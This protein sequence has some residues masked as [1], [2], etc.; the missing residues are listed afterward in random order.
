MQTPDSVDSLVTEPPCW[1]GTL[2]GQRTCIYPPIW[3]KGSAVAAGGE[4]AKLCILCGSTN[5]M[6]TCRRVS[7]FASSEMS[8]ATGAPRSRTAN[9]TAFSCSIT[10][11][12]GGPR[13]H[14]APGR[15]RR[16]QGVARGPAR[17][18]DRQ[19]RLSLRVVFGGDGGGGPSRRIPHCPHRRHRHAGAGGRSRA[20]AGGA[21]LAI[22]QPLSWQCGAGEPLTPDDFSFAMDRACPGHPRRSRTRGASSP[23]RA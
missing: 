7:S 14:A 4:D 9:K 2:L 12:P 22:R 6:T 3:L 1:R 20:A 23:S 5:N 15:S 18:R 8:K 13:Q 16:Q 21:L 11:R 10:I 19:F 17:R